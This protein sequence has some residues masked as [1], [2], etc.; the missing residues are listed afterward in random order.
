MKF[1]FKK[2]STKFIAVGVALTVALSANAAILPHSAYAMTS[3]QKGNNL[4]NKANVYLGR[5]YQF[6]ASTNTTRVFD[7]SSFTKYVFGQNGIYL[8]RT[9]TQQS[10][11]G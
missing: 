10:K 5:D 11:M 2:I 1:T 6:G 7:C 8:P 4:I 3:T 9:S